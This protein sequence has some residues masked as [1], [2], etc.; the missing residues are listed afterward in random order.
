MARPAGVEPAAFGFGGQRSI[1][2]SYGR[3]AAHV[4]RPLRNVK[5]FQAIYGGSRHARTGT[6]SPHCHNPPTRPN[7]ATAGTPPPPGP[8]GPQPF[9]SPHIFAQSPNP[10]ATAATP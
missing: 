3:V 8:R 9:A 4:A 5:Q 10:K 6:A 7:R 1:Q 2:L